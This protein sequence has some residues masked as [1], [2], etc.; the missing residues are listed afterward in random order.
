MT[1]AERVS[2]VADYGFSERQARFLVLVM[3][4]AGLCVEAAV[5]R[6]SP[7]SRTAVRSATRF[8][9][10]SSAADSPSQ[11][12]CIQTARTSIT[13]TTN[14]SITPS[15]N[16]IRRYRRAVPARAAAE[17]LMRLDAALMSADVEW[18][19]TRA[20]KLAWLRTTAASES[21]DRR[22]GLPVPPDPAVAGQLPGTFPIALDPRGPSCSWCT[23]RQSH[24]RTTSGPSCLAT[25]RRFGSPK[26]WTLRVVFPPA[27]RRALPAYEAVVDEELGSPLSAESVSSSRTTSFTA[28]AAPTS[29]RC[30]TRC[31]PSSVAARRGSAGRGSRTC[32]GGG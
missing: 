5:R 13:S 26:S 15:A 18:L 7:G 6:P 1:T 25:R 3:R 10:S 21:R 28:D 23:S 2:A 16:L 27:L 22:E 14:R 30:Q 17:R 4:H 29:R 19:T 20:E 8:S 24:G 32:I 11:A 12:D 31:A 9:P